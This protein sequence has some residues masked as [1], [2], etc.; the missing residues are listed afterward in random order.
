MSFDQRR[1]TD[2]AKGLFSPC[3][4]HACHLHSHSSF[5]CLLLS[6][7]SSFTLLFFCLYRFTLATGCS[8]ISLAS[9][10]Q[11]VTGNPMRFEKEMI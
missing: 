6:F 10:E 11:R 8:V 9:L 2:D 5:H 3:L 4:T 1:I 7:V